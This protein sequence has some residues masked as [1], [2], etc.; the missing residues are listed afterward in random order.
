M[1]VGHYGVS[2][3]A[4]R[5]APKLSLGWLFL[6]VQ[7]L[8]LL[9]ASFVL[10]GIEKLAI[11]PGFTAY[12]PYDLFFMP[13]SHSLVGALAWSV[14]LGLMTR[15]LAGRK[16]RVAAVAVAVF[17]HWVLDVPMHTADMPLA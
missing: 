2:L 15:A 4:K 8:D 7:T 14:L 13:Y 9:F 1:F 10:L 16:H 12:N 17:S 11:V 3:A 6:A 5:W